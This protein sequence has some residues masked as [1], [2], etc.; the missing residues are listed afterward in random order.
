MSL[1]VSSSKTFLFIDESGDHGLTRID[2]DFPVFLLC[3][4]LVDE[5]E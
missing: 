2:T 4:V 3:G 5:G 1:S